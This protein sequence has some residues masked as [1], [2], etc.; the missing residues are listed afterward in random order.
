MSIKFTTRFFLTFS[1]I[2]FLMLLLSSCST[3][4]SSP[5]AQDDR[6][7]VVTSSSIA[8]DFVTRIAGSSVKVVTLV[9]NSTDTHTYEPAAS[10]LKELQNASLVVLPD[11]DLNPTISQVVGISVPDSI[12]LD[13]NASSLDDSDFIFKDPVNN[14][15]RNVHT[16]TDPVLA[17]KWIDS[18]ATRLIELVPD[19]AQDITARSDSLRSELSSLDESIVSRLQSIPEPN[20]KLVVYHDAWEYF[21]KRYQLPV[22]GALQAVDFTEPSASE[23]A[24]MSNQIKSENVPAFFGSEV[25][26]S[27]V[28]ETLQQESGARYIPDLA[29]DALQGS[30]GDSNH[31][32]VFL[33]DYN[34]D[35]IVN[36]LS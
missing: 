36:G 23:L 10:D 9:P 31:S 15:G 20:R 14:S 26:P 25:F 34:T 6:P 2:T 17:S 5:P 18:L 13:L 28:M 12:V 21:G 32:Y 27:D 33:M 19:A 4:T 3:D 30:P 1:V 11:K 7:I 16:W 35:L 22:V 24:A 29:D 8:S